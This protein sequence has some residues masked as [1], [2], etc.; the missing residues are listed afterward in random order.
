MLESQQ[1]VQVNGWTDFLKV[2]P[3]WKLLEEDQKYQI[4]QVVNRNLLD[5]LNLMFERKLKQ[6]HDR[7]EMGL[8]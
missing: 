1:N 8:V 7:F 6:G 2:K 4:L 5:L 3:S